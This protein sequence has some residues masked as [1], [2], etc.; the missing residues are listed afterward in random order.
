MITGTAV[1]SIHLARLPPTVMAGTG[2][3]M[4]VGGKR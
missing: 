2:P 3:A 1:S 4:T